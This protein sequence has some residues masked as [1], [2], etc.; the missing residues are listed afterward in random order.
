MPRQRDFAV[1]QPKHSASPD[2]AVGTLMLKRER[3]HPLLNV[4]AGMAVMTLAGACAHTSDQVYGPASAPPPPRAT[5]SNAVDEAPAPAAP[6]PAGEEPSAA[7]TPNPSA[8]SY[9]D[10]DPG[11]LQ[12]FHPALDAYGTWSDDP[13]YG[14]VWTPSAAETGPDF[15]PYV[16]GGHWVYGDDY[17]WSSDYTWGW[18]PFH[19]GRWVHL[20]ARGWS[21]IPGREYAPA[22]VEWRTGDAY[23]GWTPAPPLFVW[24]GGIAVTLGFAPPTPPFVYCAHA[25]LFASRPARVVITGPRALAIGRQ[26]RFYGAPNAHGHFHPGPPLASL[27]IAPERVVRATGHERGLARARAFSRPSSAARIGARPARA[28]ETHAH[29]A[30][31][32]GARP[33]ADRAEGARPKVKRT[34]VARPKL[35]HAASARPKVTRAE[36]P[37]QE[38]QAERQA[39]E[40]NQ[41]RRQETARPGATRLEGARSEHVS[42]QVRSDREPSHVE[43]HASRPGSDR[44]ASP[45]VTRK[46]ATHSEEPTHE[47]SK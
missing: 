36:R 44:S 2:P 31:R 24:R 41:A 15:V 42:E 10:T 27:H 34:E 32:E 45:Q 33:K 29:A 20:E 1:F 14:S 46:P 26:T 11:A 35:A 16:S 4:A 9:S 12:D 5:G 17:A 30:Q 7:S 25:D 19:Y 3:A 37:H 18:A 8:E 47:R 28:P 6:V 22:W 39:A 13:T 38:G 43:A 40:P 23:V 21:W